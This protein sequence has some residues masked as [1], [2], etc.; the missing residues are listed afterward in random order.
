MAINANCAGS[1]FS[2]QNACTLAANCGAAFTLL[3]PGV[4]RETVAGR[5]LTGLVLENFAEILNICAQL[6][7]ERATTHVALHEVNTDR[8]PFA[9]VHCPEDKVDTWLDLDVMVSGY[10]AGRLLLRAMT[11]GTERSDTRGG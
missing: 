11:L 7:N 9:G 1:I 10:G 8:D 3:P 4:A 5:K 2:L 6:L